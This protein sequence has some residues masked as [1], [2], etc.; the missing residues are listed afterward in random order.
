[1]TDLLQ[2][3]S[4]GCFTSASWKNLGCSCNLSLIEIGFWKNTFWQFCTF[5]NDVRPKKGD[6][7]PL[8]VILSGA[9]S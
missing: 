9:S 7:K 6:K 8:F 4:H 2:D 1:K 5:V 3:F